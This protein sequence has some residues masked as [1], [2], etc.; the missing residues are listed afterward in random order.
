M[1]QIE[2]NA[3]SDFMVSFGTHAGMVGKNNEDYVAFA[4]FDTNGKSEYDERIILHLGVVADGVGGQLAGERASQLATQT[5]VNYFGDIEDLTI[6]EVG[7]HFDKAVSM[8]N[9]AV[10][11]ETEIYPEN[12]GMATTIAVVAVMDGLLFT[13]HVGDSRIYLHRENTL[14]Q[15]T[16]DH[17]WVQEALQAGIINEAEAK[18]HPNRN[19]IRRSLGT[20]DT[21]A[22]DQRM[23]S[24]AQ[25]H[26]WQGMPIRKGDSVLLCSDGLTDM[27]SEYD[28]KLSLEEEVEEM[29]DLVVNLIDKA[30]QA[31][32]RD[33]ITV[34]VI[35]TAE[36]YKPNRMMP[37][38]PSIDDVVHRTNKGP[39]PEK[40]TL[41]GQSIKS[42]S[43]APPT[44]RSMPK[45]TRDM[46]RAYNHNGNPELA[47][48][49]QLATVKMKT[50][51]KPIKT[52]KTKTRKSIDKEALRITQPALEKS[53]FEL[54]TPA[55]NEPSSGEFQWW[56][57]RIVLGL[58]ILAALMTI[59]VFIMSQLIQ[60]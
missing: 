19:I 14:Y 58:A 51:P 7:D 22:A 53:D 50:V 39:E 37:I 8:A 38:P 12:K 46:L 6:E 24:G 3:V 1:K 5:V 25:D 27:I 9:R 56:M 59:F 33:N 2:N 42:N 55:E 35:R 41:V 49:N 11:E 17:S 16:N 26:F 47:L 45:V 20:M 34:M 40:L 60:G 23:L 21:V 31:G 44:I 36:D 28:V 4:A 18:Q 52:E 29:S 30:N 13:A 57:V 43:V 10:I 48:P 54:D 15:I 32:G